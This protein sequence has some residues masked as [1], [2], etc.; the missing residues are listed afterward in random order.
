MFS[1]S[2]YFGVFF[3]VAKFIMHW[4]AG[5]FWGTGHEVSAASGHYLLASGPQKLALMYVRVLD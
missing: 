1:H 3:L 5:S 4:V 2:G